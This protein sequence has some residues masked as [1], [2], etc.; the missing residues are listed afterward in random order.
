LSTSKRL[1]GL[2]I[3]VFMEDEPER[4]LRRVE[5]ALTLIKVH[6]GLRYDRLIR[7]VQRVWMKILPGALGN[8]NRALNACELDAR[9]VRAETS[10]AEQI[11]SVIVHEATHARLF[12]CGIGYSEDLR[13]RVEA[14]CFRSQLAFSARLP[15]GEQIR[16]EAERKLRAYASS[17]IWT[18]AAMRVRHVEASVAVLQQLG[19][20]AWLVKLA[21]ALRR[22]FGGDSKPRRAMTDDRQPDTE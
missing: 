17:D 3:G 16:A 20:P 5:E 11:A 18:D 8:Y 15:N 6:D 10:S 14:V 1:D 19:C 9:F 4:I 2:W 21:L 7:D 22:L 12:K 13:P